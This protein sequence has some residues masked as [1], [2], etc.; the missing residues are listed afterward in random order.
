MAQIHEKKSEHIGSL[1]QQTFF[2]VKYERPAKSENVQIRNKIDGL[3][4]EGVE[5]RMSFFK[6][7]ISMKRWEAK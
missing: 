1:Q 2:F 5:S 3:K 7:I 4:K 6:E